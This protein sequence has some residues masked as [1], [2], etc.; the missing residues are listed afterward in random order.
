M[1]RYLF[2]RRS[3]SYF[4][5]RRVPRDLRHQYA[6][7]YIERNIGRMSAADARARVA[8]INGELE[9]DFATMRRGDA[10]TAAQI[11][12]IRLAAQIDAHKTMK[13]NP[14]SSPHRL[15]DDL[16]AFLPNVETDAREAL[17]AAGVDPSDRNLS[18]AVDAIYLGTMG[19][20]ALYEKGVEPPAVESAPIGG[21]TVLEAATAYQDAPDVA[22][23]GKTRRQ[24]LSS[25]RLFSDHVGRDKPVAAIVACK[26]A[27]LGPSLLQGR[28]GARVQRL[29]LGAI[30]GARGGSGGTSLGSR[31]CYLSTRAGPIAMAQPPLREGFPFAPRFATPRTC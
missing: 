2:E 1:T 31:G 18:Q 16:D 28:N 15:A 6:G 29:A 23:T 17:L 8:V 3:G 11:E 10:A 21:T 30:R 7:S 27:S 4:Y 20:Q 22:T 25:A 26:P 5:K 14:L 12:R 13:T 24:L 19:A 9:T